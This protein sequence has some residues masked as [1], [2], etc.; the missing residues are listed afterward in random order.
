[1]PYITLSGNRYFLSPG[2]EIVEYNIDVQGPTQ[3]QQGVQ[4][5]ADNIKVNRYAFDD[6]VK[7]GIGTGR[8]R[9]EKGRGIGA[10]RFS[11]VETRFESFVELALLE[12]VTTHA[13]PS[14][15]LKKYVLYKGELW[16][17][18]EH[19]YNASYINSIEAQ[20]FNG[21]N[22]TWDGDTGPTD[23]D[24]N[25]VGRRVFD[26]VVWKGYIQVLTNG[27]HVS[28]GVNNT[29][30][31]YQVWA[32]DGSTAWG[33][34]SD[35][36]SWPRSGSSKRYLPAAI[37][38]RHNFDDDMG[39]ILAFGNT[40]YVA[41][42][43]HP[44]STDG[45]G[46][47]EIFKRTGTGNNTS[48]TWT[49]VTTVA[50]G[51]GPK[52]LVSWFNRSG[53]LVPILVTRENIYAID[54]A[55]STFEELVPFTVLSGA[56]A[57]GRWST[58]GADGALYVPLANGDILRIFLGSEV[59]GGV[60]SLA[61]ENIGPHTKAGAG[62]S[63]DGFPIIFQGHANYLLG[64]DPS[65][66]F[67][68]YGGHDSTNSTATILAY[69]YLNRSWHH[70]HNS[71]DD[72]TMATE[73]DIYMLALS[74][75]DD[76]VLRLHFA[77]E[78]AA[79]AASDV[80]HLETPLTSGAAGGTK[81]YT[82]GGYLDIAEDDLT[83]PHSSSAVLL[84]LVDDDGITADDTGQYIELEYGLN[85]ADWDDVST[86]GR[87]V[88]GDKQLEFG[89]T[90]QNTTGASE[91]G[92]PIGV[93]AKTIRVRL[94]FKRASTTTLTPKLKEFELQARNRIQVING[95]RFPVDLEETATQ[96][97]I[98]VE[99]VWDRLETIRDTVPLV[100]LIWGKESNGTD[101]THYVEMVPP[102]P[103]Q[104]TLS[105]PE[106]MGENKKDRYGTV[107]VT[108]EEVIDV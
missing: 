9:R 70:I 28:A 8:M 89:R 47:I 45:D 98:T 25:A 87:F 61:I 80:M 50:S 30:K 103:A 65:W 11:T 67:V 58:V 27:D 63:G 46:F 44:D 91:A 33:E 99:A 106:Q 18:N 102:M 77:G 75:A 38:R 69:D 100:P 6:W 48:D 26:A 54:D 92:T 52:A 37:T 1:M 21:S 5:R 62:R 16:A 96:E 105:G 73:E 43:R 59:A 88:S 84:G 34:T 68:A 24:D 60:H 64:V 95:Y 53:A 36:A 7:Q 12:S 3:R 86:L 83:D 20:K 35:V 85:G 78:G 4:R 13:S 14:N 108:L 57:D 93:S 31:N 104:I 66:L 74:A 49:S 81:N 41:I 55:N 76:D 32:F 82:D 17:F 10:M 23:A 56:A 79:G 101:T 15:Y 19:L 51:D 97:Q 39:K 40:L 72:G 2:A 90:G 94:V 22:D 29:E 71:A 42:Y 107:L